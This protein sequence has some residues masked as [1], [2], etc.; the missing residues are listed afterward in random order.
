MADEKDP[1]PRPLPEPIDDEGLERW[2]VQYQYRDGVVLSNILL[3]F[4]IH[5]RRAKLSETAVTHYVGAVRRG[6]E[7]GDPIEALRGARSRG[8]AFIARSAV[9]R[10]AEWRKDGALSARVEAMP[11]LPHSAA[12]AASLKPKV[13]NRILA[14][15]MGQSEP[16][17]SFLVLVILSGLRVGSL[18]AMDRRRIGTWLH[19]PDARVHG[20]VA[21]LFGTP[22]WGTLGRLLSPAGYSA[23][24]AVLRRSLARACRDAGVEYVAP[25]EFRR[26]ALA[27][28]PRS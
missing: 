12:K 17:R 7:A 14:Q 26:L 19:S 1:G 3:K 2:M 23:S 6:L 4:E 5:L 11:F 21:A 27:E 22:R 9:T 16:M 28:A 10:W 25:E 15:A 20:A 18:F 13:R 8:S 24:Y